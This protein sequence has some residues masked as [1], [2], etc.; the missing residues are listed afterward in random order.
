MGTFDT[1]AAAASPHFFAAFGQSVTL[2]PPGGA[3]Q[4]VEAILGDELEDWAVEELTRQKHYS[5]DCSLDASLA[6]AAVKG[7]TVTA[8]GYTYTV[9]PPARR[10]AAMLTVRL[11]R[12]ED[13][14]RATERRIN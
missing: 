3:A 10:D 12:S 7:A 5:R 4:V 2:T 11:V 13:V 8:D 6:D 14:R 9:Q 1:L